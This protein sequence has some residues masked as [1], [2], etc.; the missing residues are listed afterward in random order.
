LDGNFNDADM[1][2]DTGSR[3]KKMEKK[4]RLQLNEVFS[5]TFPGKRT[6]REKFVLLENHMALNGG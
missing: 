5:L 6:N 1:V 2:W 3:G 4:I